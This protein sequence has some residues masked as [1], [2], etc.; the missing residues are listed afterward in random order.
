MLLRAVPLFFLPLSPPACADFLFSFIPGTWRWMLGI[1]ALP[2][3]VQMAG[4]ALLPESPRWLAS[5]GR[6]AAADH[7]LQQLQPGRVRVVQA[8]PGRGGGGMDAAG[9][10]GAASGSDGGSS[11]GGVGVSSWRLLRSRIVLKELHVGI[12]LQ[13]LQQV[14]GIN[15]VM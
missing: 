8:V 7:A 2:A 1:A 13:V 14:A 9:S 3:L 4:L 11:I 6:T 10:S 12:G 5:K 15:T